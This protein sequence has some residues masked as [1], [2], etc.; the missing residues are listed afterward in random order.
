MYICMQT[1]RHTDILIYILIHILI[2][3]HIHIHAHTYT[4]IHTYIYIHIHTRTYARHIVYMGH[5]ATQLAVLG[6][7]YRN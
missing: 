3:I 6:C 2:Y 1:Y 5:K 4:Y 7:G